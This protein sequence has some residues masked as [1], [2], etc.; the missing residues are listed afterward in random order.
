MHG[1]ALRTADDSDGLEFPLTRVHRGEES[2]PLGAVGRT[3]GGIFNIAAGIDLTVL[4]QQR[5]A[6]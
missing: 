5:C 4:R 2:R 1:L 3:E 6:E